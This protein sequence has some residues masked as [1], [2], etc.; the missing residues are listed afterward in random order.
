[1]VEYSYVPIVR[2]F[3][4]Q[5]ISV[6]EQNRE[7]PEQLHINSSNQGITWEELLK[8][9]ASV[10][11][12]SGGSGKSTEVLQ[13]ANLL[14]ESGTPAFVLRLDALCRNSLLFSFRKEDSEGK[15]SFEE[16]QRSK[17]PAVVFLDALDEAL[18]PEGEHS[19]KLS[20]ALA[21]LS[22]GVGKTGCDLKI[23]LTTRGGG[24]WQGQSDI[25]ILKDHLRRLRVSG[26][27]PSSKEDFDVKVG[28]FDI[29][30]L[31]AE[32]VEQI[33][34]S[35]LASTSEFI[36]A[37]SNSLSSDLMQQPLEVHFLIDLWKDGIAIGLQA[38][39]IFASR[40]QVFDR[41]ISARLRTQ[42]G[43]KRRSNL[44][45]TIA[46]RACE[47]LAAAT[48]IANIPAINLQINDDSSMDALNILST[49]TDSWSEGEVRQLFAC[50]VFQEAAEGGVRFAHREIQDFLAANFFKR[51]MNENA[52]SLEVLS[53]LLGYGLGDPQIPPST[54]QTMGWLATMN[55]E[56]KKYI[57]S[58]KP[59]LLI[60]TGDP[61]SLSID[62]R[63]RALRAHVESYG[64]RQYLGEWFHNNDLRKFAMP[65]LSTTVAELLIPLRLRA[66][67]QR[68][69]RAETLMNLGPPPRTR[70][71]CKARME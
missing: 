57:T 25:N 19:N 43:E 20:D 71:F 5:D 67:Q 11:L 6:S 38:N 10:I 13:R 37:V 14:R 52:G 2:R 53:P 55:P 28:A 12:G 58:L 39:E 62:E 27:G 7:N 31:D 21:R 69:E 65:E 32:E 29:A 56:A 54:E 30:K 9:D 23:V 24:G 41:I 8:F 66:V 18:L 16:W 46:R 64:N 17:G 60:E 42:D 68:M 33:A 45:P 34:A 15:S 59:S 40:H 70:Q 35:R 50:S 48:L 3:I 4:E 51:A 22:E 47:K 1:M 44:D 61:R 26:S 63:E 49:D 36:E